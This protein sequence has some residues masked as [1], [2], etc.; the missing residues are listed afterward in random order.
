[1]GDVHQPNGGDQHGEMKPPI[2][3]PHLAS[4]WLG[5][6]ERRRL[7]EERRELETRFTCLVKNVRDHAIFTLDNGGRITSWNVE[8]E[9]ILGYSE[10]EAVGK[11]FRL[12]FTDEDIGLGVFL[13]NIAPVATNMT[14]EE[15]HRC[16]LCLLQ[17]FQCPRRGDDLSKREQRLAFGDHLISCCSRCVV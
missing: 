11:H 9:R 17:S 5:V 4:E 7:E 8:A 12:I 14:S 10:E 15:L 16:L 6:T 3:P 13:A 2:L 1:M